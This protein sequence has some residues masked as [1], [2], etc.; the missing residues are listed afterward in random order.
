MVVYSFSSKIKIEIQNIFSILLDY[1]FGTI[2]QKMPHLIIPDSTSIHSPHQEQPQPQCSICMGDFDAGDAQV[3]LGCDHQFHYACILQWNLASSDQNHQSCPLC[4][5]DMEVSDIV[6][7]RPRVAQPQTFTGTPIGNIRS[8]QVSEVVNDQQG[9]ELT[10]RDCNSQLNYCEM[11]GIYVCQ[12]QY[13][14]NDQNWSR[15][16]I[17]SRP[18]PFGTSEDDQD[19][20]EGE[21]PMVHC[22][23]CFEN[24]EEFVL[25][26]MMDDHGDIDVFYHE[27]IQELYEEFFID[28]SGNNNEELYRYYPSY[29]FDEF[30]DH[31]S[32]R[33]QAELRDEFAMEA[34]IDEDL[35]DGEYS[36]YINDEEDQNAREPNFIN[37]PVQINLNNDENVE[38]SDDPVPND[39]IVQQI[40]G[41]HFS[42]NEPDEIRNIIQN[43]P[44]DAIENHNL[45]DSYI[46][47]FIQYIINNSPRAGDILIDINNELNVE[48]NNEIDELLQEDIPQVPDFLDQEPNND[49]GDIAVS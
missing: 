26:F 15:R 6:A 29:T 13:T 47:E 23:H 16:T 17:H 5:D 3:R 45:D 33:F 2:S 28:T 8:H 14:H 7:N 18:N 10:C 34:P 49:G 38:T 27:R 31:M 44:V 30:R 22:S 19:L 20:E 21:I 46:Q 36:D 11:C 4:R 40:T 42:M 35:D 41:I 43:N 32:E 25:D 37:E 24:R 39:N 48:I 1:P 9:L 12:C